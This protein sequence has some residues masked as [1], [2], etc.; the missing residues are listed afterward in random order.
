[1]P[2]RPP[3]PGGPLRPIIA[4]I[5][6]YKD[7]GTILLAARENAP[8]LLENEHI[9]IYPDF[10]MA[11]QKARNTFREVKKTLQTHNLKYAMLFPARLKIIHN[12]KSFFFDNPDDAMEW[13][14][15]TLTPHSSQKSTQD[16][17]RKTSQKENSGKLKMDRWK[18][19]GS[20]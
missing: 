15:V 11:V 12:Q 20:L 6:N 7:R 4:R 2:S 13:A 19:M 1:M 10:T 3:R 9:S 17:Q 18:K 8:L 5:L 16:S 14:E